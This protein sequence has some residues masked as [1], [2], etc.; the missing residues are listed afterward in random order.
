M[1]T[2]TFQ[3]SCLMVVDFCCQTI[4]GCVLSYC[5]NTHVCGVLRG[6]MNDGLMMKGWG[7]KNR[8]GTSLIFFKLSFLSWFSMCPC[9]YALCVWAIYF[10]STIVCVEKCNCVWK[11]YASRYDFTW[12][13]TELVQCL[14][15]SANACAFVINRDVILYMYG[16]ACAQVNMENMPMCVLLLVWDPM[17]TH[18]NVHVCMCNYLGILFQL[19]KCT[20][21]FL[22]IYWYICV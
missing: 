19:C 3:Q 5:E 11:W 21:V 17:N 15:L 20:S 7:V 6:T 14:C 16:F 4:V 1:I 2:T 22:C 9:L 12:N 8:G 18:M 13:W 10:Y